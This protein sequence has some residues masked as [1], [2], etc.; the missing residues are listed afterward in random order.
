MFQNIEDMFQCYEIK[1]FKGFYWSE[2]Y[3]MGAQSYISL[4]HLLKYESVLNLTL[5][6]ISETEVSVSFSK[7]IANFNL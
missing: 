5:Y 6:A 1:G 7:T 2:R 4:K 3:S